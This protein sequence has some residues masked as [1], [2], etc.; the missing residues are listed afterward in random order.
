MI[1]KNTVDFYQ[2]AILAIARF[3]SKG[4]SD[5]FSIVIVELSEGKLAQQSLV[6]LHINGK[7]NIWTM[8]G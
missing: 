1:D 6:G 3:S 7:K 2:I 8:C 5:C 4:K